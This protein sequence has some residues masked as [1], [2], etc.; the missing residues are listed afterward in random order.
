[1]FVLAHPLDAN[2]PA[3]L[4]ATVV[5]QE[6]RSRNGFTGVTIS[7]ALEAGALGNFG[8]TGNRAVLA[9]Q[10]GVDLILASARDV[11]QGDAA[12]TALAGA[13]ADGALDSGAFGDALARVRALRASLP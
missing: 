10:A 7:D 11:G 1:M 2:R 3:G 8:S 12:A 9:A 5:Q 4:S 13:L 6:L